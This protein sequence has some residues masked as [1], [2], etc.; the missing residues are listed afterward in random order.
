M[1]TT[2]E[3]PVLQEGRGSVRPLTG[4]LLGASLSASTGL[5]LTPIAPRTPI[6]YFPK[7]PHQ[8]PPPAAIGRSVPLHRGQ[9]AASRTYTSPDRTPVHRPMIGTKLPRHPMSGFNYVVWYASGEQ[10]QLLE[11]TQ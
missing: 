1:P 11:F 9:S 6:Q 10:D 5:R 8:R 2:A 3:Q 4:R 7:I